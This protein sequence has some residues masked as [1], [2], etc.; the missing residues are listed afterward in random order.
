MNIHPPVR[1]IKG[2]SEIFDRMDTSV[3]DELGKT[4]SCDSY[5]RSKGHFCN[6]FRGDVVRTIVHFCF[7]FRVVEVERG[8][9]INSK[10]V[11]YT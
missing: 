10:R 4:D 5:E 7:S 1:E 6:A 3:H 11:I 2:N 9:Y 8:I